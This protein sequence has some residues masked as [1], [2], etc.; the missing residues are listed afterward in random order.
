[1][2]VEKITCDYCE[3]DLTETGKTPK[4][5]LSLRA[6]ELPH[7]TAMIHAVM[8]HPPISREHHLCNLGC[9]DKWMGLKNHE[10]S[11]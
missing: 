2:K 9:L 4:Y 7:N 3:K 6:E 1:M 10:P 5:R 11:P 8:I